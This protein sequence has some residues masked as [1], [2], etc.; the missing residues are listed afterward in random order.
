MAKNLDNVHDPFVRKIVTGD[1]TLKQRFQEFLQKA[2]LSSH[3][4]VVAERI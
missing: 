4:M 1:D 2:G 3:M